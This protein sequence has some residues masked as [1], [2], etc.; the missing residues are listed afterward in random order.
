MV[1]L[2][3]RIKEERECHISNLEQPMY[4]SVDGHHFLGP[5][6]SNMLSESVSQYSTVIFENF[7]IRVQNS[8][9]R[10]SKKDDCAIMSSNI[11]CLVKN[12]L[13]RNGK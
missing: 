11:V 6:P 13:N 8:K 3:N 7:T 4:P 1:Q 9:R 10:S 5:L 2:Y 12:I